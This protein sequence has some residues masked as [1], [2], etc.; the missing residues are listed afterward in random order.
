MAKSGKKTIFLELIYSV[1]FTSAI[2]QSDSV[3]HIYT[4]FLTVV[5]H[6]IVSAVPRVPILRV[7]ASV[8]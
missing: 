7:R 2:Q 6:G 5:Y 8:C 4:F 3:T 1:V